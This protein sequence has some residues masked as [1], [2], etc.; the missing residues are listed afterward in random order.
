M[1]FHLRPTQ[2]CHRCIRYLS[3]LIIPSKYLRFSLCA[4]MILIVTYIYLQT[5][6]S[7][8]FFNKTSYHPS[9]MLFRFTTWRQ[10]LCIQQVRQSL[11]SPLSWKTHSLSPHSHFHFS[12][13][14]NIPLVKPRK[15]K[16]LS[17]PP[18]ILNNS[19]SLPLTY[20]RAK[21]LTLYLLSIYHHISQYLPLLF[22]S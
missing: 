4:A 20:T 2:L 8:A 13:L 18:S 14:I 16:L 10:M 17:S 1:Y 19:L 22:P 21:Q 11:F 15:T 5:F 9:Q 12:S 6:S 3:I 7:F